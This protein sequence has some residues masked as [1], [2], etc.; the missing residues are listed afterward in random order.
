MPVLGG[1]SH[2]A[3]GICSRGRKGFS[4]AAILAS[5]DAGYVNGAL[6]FVDGGQLA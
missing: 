5:R 4:A 6:L 2:C 3:E 1:I